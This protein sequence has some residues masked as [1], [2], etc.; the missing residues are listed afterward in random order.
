MLRCGKPE[1]RRIAVIVLLFAV[2]ILV[3]QNQGCLPAL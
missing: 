1:L 2:S 3:K